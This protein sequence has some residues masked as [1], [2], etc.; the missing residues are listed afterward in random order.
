MLRISLQR[1][2]Q[3]DNDDWLFGAL[4]F[5]GEKIIHHQCRDESGDTKILLRIVI[6]HMQPK[7]ITSAGKPCQ[8]LVHG[9][10]LFVCPLTNR[11]QQSAPSSTQI[12]AC[13][14]ASRCGEELSQIS[15]VKI[16][17]RIFI[18]LAFA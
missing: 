17:I 6:Q 3:Y 18:K 11:V 10:F 15:V 7:F 2:A 1:F 8:E 4:E 12:G 14:D 9:K 5:A 16:W 13:L